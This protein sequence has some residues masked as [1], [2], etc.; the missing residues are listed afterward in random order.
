ML[1]NFVHNCSNQNKME[2][3]KKEEKLSRI[4]SMV[5]EFVMDKDLGFGRCVFLLLRENF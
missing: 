1:V 5:N 4:I 2:K 3:K